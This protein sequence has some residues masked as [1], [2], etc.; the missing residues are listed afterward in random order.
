MAGENIKHPDHPG[1]PGLK[2]ALQETGLSAY[3]LGDVLG[4]PRT[5]TIYDRINGCKGSFSYDQMARIQKYVFPDRT[6]YELFGILG[7]DVRKVR[8][9]ADAAS[10]TRRVFEEHAGIEEWSKA[11]SRG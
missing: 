2:R 1:Y 8:E 11:T 9:T 5:A 4:I 10:E 3:T 6:L 7:E